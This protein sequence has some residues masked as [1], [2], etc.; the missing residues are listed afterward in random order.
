MKKKLESELVSIAHRILKLKGKEDVVKMHIEAKEL[1]EKLSIL[2]FLNENLNDQVQETTNPSSLFSVLDVTFNNKLSNSTKVETITNTT[3]EREP[4][5]PL[6]APLTNPIKKEVT[7]VPVPQE[8]PAVN[9]ELNAV[10]QEQPKVAPPIK[11]QD[12]EAKELPVFEPIAK[13]QTE[14][15][16]EKKSINDIIN[17]KRLNIGLNDKIAF[18]KHLFDG[19]STDYDRVISQLNT[20]QTFTEAQ[21]LITHI[22]KPE[23]N[24]W[25]GKEDVE[26]RFIN[27]VETKFI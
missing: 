20:I 10:K 24:N 26:E 16:S 21:H 27:I 19:E 4:E 22:V 18:V 15:V 23:Y 17:T 5:S 8:V 12:I 3:Q 6:A 7:P 13:T 11:T 9:T 2:K 25:E 14:E 1:F